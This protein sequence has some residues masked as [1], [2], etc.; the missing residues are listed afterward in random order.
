MGDNIEAFTRATKPGALYYD[1]I[2]AG[3][4]PMERYQPFDEIIKHPNGMHGY[5][6]MITIDGEGR[7][8]DGKYSFV[9]KKGDIIL[10]PPHVP[11]YYHINTSSDTWYYKW[12]F[13]YA[14]DS[15]LPA[16]GS[17][18]ALLQLVD[19]GRVYVSDNYEERMKASMEA[20]YFESELET[21]SRDPFEDRDYRS[22]QRGED[23]DN[24]LVLATREQLEE[25]HYDGQIGLFHVTQGHYDEF[26]RLFREIIMRT[27]S[28]EEFSQMLA[29]NYLEQILF[30][31]LEILSKKELIMQDSR[32]SKACLYIKDHINRPR[33]TVEEIA[34]AVYLSP[35]RISH[36]FETNMGMSIIKWRDIE[37]LK[38]AK[39]LLINTDHKI[40][41]IAQAI[42][43][44]DPA[45][46]FKFFKRNCGMTPSKYRAEMKLKSN[47]SDFIG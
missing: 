11:H 32:V 20:A 17:A 19:E 45:Y 30:R 36:L 42:G 29:A 6:L 12:V 21:V 15:W 4:T 18:P 46:F 24:S 41:Q 16:L 28:S 40:E 26:S 7:V 31:R 3:I 47:F 2:V 43:I 13:F 8:C 38:L 1:T 35:S 33:M 44:N 39:W 10:F 27:N 34:S 5:V 23:G 14:R 37:R 25:D 22:S 9:S